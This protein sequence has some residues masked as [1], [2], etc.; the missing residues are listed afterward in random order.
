[1]R[2]GHSETLAKVHSLR[3]TE[4]HG[5]IS[6]DQRA[7]WM[8]SRTAITGSAVKIEK[9]R[10]RTEFQCLAALIYE[11]LVMRKRALPSDDTA[12]S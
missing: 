9:L 1:M 8:R 10:S 5:S 3:I 11:M 6:S 2:N 7:A 4:F 12:G